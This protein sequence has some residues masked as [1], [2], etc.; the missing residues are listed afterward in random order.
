MVK[1]KMAVAVV[2]AVLTVLAPAMAV[3]QIGPVPP[4]GDFLLRNV[5]TGYCADLPW[6]GPGTVDGPVNQWHCRPGPQ[7]NQ[8]WRRVFD[9]GG[10]SGPL[11]F[12]LQNTADGL[13]MD[14]PYY[15][16]VPPGTP[17][18]EYYCR[19]G[20]DDNQAFSLTLGPT[21]WRF[22]HNKTGLCLVATGGLDA[23][24]TLDQ[25]YS[26]GDDWRTPTA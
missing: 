20:S 8:V 23:R 14:V 16:A 19:P 12:A 5:Q 7:D 15:D 26:G 11:G 17:I 10:G 6:F 13:C 18:S 21:G 24:L 25:C 4:Q 2:V 1:R 22:Y 9:G 3:A